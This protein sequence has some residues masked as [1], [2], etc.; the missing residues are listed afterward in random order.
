M[1]HMILFFMANDESYFDKK[2]DESYDSFKYNIFFMVVA[3]LD[4]PPSEKWM[5]IYS[6]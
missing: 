1:N 3:N 5:L 4:E 2:N 6:I